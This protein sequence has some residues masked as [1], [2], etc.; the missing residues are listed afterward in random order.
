[1]LGGNGY[2]PASDS[3]TVGLVASPEDEMN[4]TSNGPFA[5]EIATYIRKLP[6]LLSEAGRFVVIKGDTVEGVFDTYADAVQTGYDHFGLDSFFVKQ[7]APAERIHSF[8]RDLDPAC[9]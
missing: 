1:M 2:S 3:A 8:S 7:I 5:Q 6:E 4:S 9:L